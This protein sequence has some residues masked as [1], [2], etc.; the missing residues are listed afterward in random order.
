[1][2]II[3]DSRAVAVVLRKPICGS[4]YDIVQRVH[5]P[6]WL[7]VIL[8]Q[9]TAGVIFVRISLYS[10]RRNMYDIR[11]EIKTCLDG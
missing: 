9:D 11:G 6:W 5:F 1:M 8:R 3:N 2:L 10:S 7:V 4:S